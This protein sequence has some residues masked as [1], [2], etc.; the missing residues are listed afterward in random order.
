M[1][2]GLP[3]Y[4]LAFV[5]AACV[6]SMP[7]WS[8]PAQAA[9]APAGYRISVLARVPYA[10]EMTVCGGALYVGTR[11][12][13]VYRVPLSGGPARP[14]VSGLIAPNGVTCL[15]GKLYVAERTRVIAY[16]P[17]DDGELKA[18]VVIRDGLPNLAHHGLR[19]IAAGPDGRL[20]ISIGSPCNICKPKGIEGTIQSM[21]PDGSDFRRVAWGIRNSVGF[22]WRDGVLY[23][24]D[25]GADM[26]GDDI[27][28]DELNRL[29]PGGFYGFPYFGGTVRLTGFDK[30]APPQKQIPPV[31]AFQAHVATLG[32][33]FYE[34]AMFPELRGSALV[35]QH[36][37]WNR[38]VP[39]GYQVVRLNSVEGSGMGETFLS[40]I[41]RPVDIK[42][43]PDGSLVV[44]D[45]R[46]GRIWRVSK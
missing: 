4:L 22:D 19:Y 34:G 12:S 42:E 17:T 28:P 38:T 29:E 37:S 2:R 45:D 9:S 8:R 26:M 21:K 33:H 44:S 10:R 36:G 41:G 3:R 15:N 27:P 5:V 1:R 6:A 11:R 7:Q 23:F 25:N 43:L 30:A 18:G 16:S 39:V 32:V 20:Y 13:S 24:T 35:A 14:V 46:G 40:D 31:F